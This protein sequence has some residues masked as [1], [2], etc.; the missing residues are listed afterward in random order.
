MIGRV[1]V[2]DRLALGGGQVF[3]ADDDLHAPPFARPQGRQARAATPR[4]A[5]SRS[6][7]RGALRIWGLVLPDNTAQ[8]LK[9]T[10]ALVKI[11]GAVVL[12]ATGESVAN[13]RGGIDRSS[14][15]AFCPPGVAF[16]RLRDHGRRATARTARSQRGP[17]QAWHASMLRLC[18]VQ[19]SATRIP[20]SLRA[21]ATTQSR[22][23]RAE[24]PDRN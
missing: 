4:S 14:G 12:E 5:L 15:E 6:D 1:A 3:A 11:T 18:C 20:D 23:I 19:P 22:Q 9:P 17:R 8:R 7:C 13:L 10:L 2:G 24:E 16:R 21:L